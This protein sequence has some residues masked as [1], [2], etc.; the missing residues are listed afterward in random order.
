L[1]H[2][3]TTADRDPGSPKQKGITTYALSPNRQRP[4]AGT[5]QSAVFN[6]WRR[7]S[8]QFFYVVP[9]FVGMYLIFSWANARWVLSRTGFGAG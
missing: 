5:L 6:T 1:S 9:P 7:S 2:P 4:L 8:A 3:G